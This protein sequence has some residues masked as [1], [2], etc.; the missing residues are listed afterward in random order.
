MPCPPGQPRSCRSRQGFLRSVLRCPVP[1]DESP[2]ESS[3]SAEKC[4]VAEYWEHMLTAYIDLMC[5]IVPA[6]FEKSDR[7]DGIITVFA[8]FL[9]NTVHTE[10][11][12]L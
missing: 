2:L 11:C 5:E 1:D 9:R 8:M 10:R 4:C 7:V 6:Y 12:S 3:R